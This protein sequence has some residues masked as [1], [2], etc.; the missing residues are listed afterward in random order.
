MAKAVSLS[1]RNVNVY[2][3]TAS[4][5]HSVPFAEKVQDFGRPLGALSSAN[6]WAAV[7]GNRQIIL[8]HRVSYID[9]ALI[10][11]RR[12]GAVSASL[13]RGHRPRK[14][15]PAQEAALA[16]QIEAHADVTLAALQA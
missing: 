4:F 11:R 9:K 13:R 3:H 5:H 15:S 12:T 2:G 7:D 10:R 6:A 1:L 14:L 8:A 16:A